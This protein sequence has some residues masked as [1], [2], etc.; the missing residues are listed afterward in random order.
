MSNLK[1]F[2]SL[3]LCIIL[4]ISAF[5]IPSSALSTQDGFVYERSED[6]TACITG[7][8]A[9]NTEIAIPSSIEGLSVKIIKKDAFEND[10]KSLKVSVPDSVTAIASDA[11]RGTKSLNV[12][13]SEN[14]FAKYYAYTQKLTANNWTDDTQRNPD[15]VTVT[16]NGKN[17]AY[18]PCKDVRSGDWYYKAAEFAGQHGFIKGYNNGSFGANDKMQRQDF[19]VILSRLVCYIEDGETEFT[20]VF[21][22]VSDREQ[23]FFSPVTYLTAKGLVSGY[24]DG[25]FGV[26]DSITREQVCTLLWR[27]AKYLGADTDIK[28]ADPLSAFSDKNKVSAFS[29]DAVKWCVEN[30]IINGSKGKLEPVKTASRAEV[31]ALIVNFVSYCIYGNKYVPAP[32]PE[33]EVVINNNGIVSNAPYYLKVNRVQNIVI[34][35]KKD[36]NGHY[37]IPVKAM[38]CSVGLNGKTP[39]GT[40]KTTD[41]YTWRL[42]S[43][44]VWGQYATRITGHYLFHSV[45]YFTQSK[46]NLEYEE[47]NKLGQAASLGCVRLSVADA[48]W[49]Y[50]NCPK[51]TVVTIYDSTAKEP[52]AKPVPIKINVNDSRRGW[53]P[54]DPDPRNPW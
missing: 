54:T 1:R 2:L 15:S 32:E 52:M 25:R 43:G 12:I 21:S 44:N 23:Y 6:G 20:P 9:G 49:I 37:N 26:G 29:Q 31:T 11:F 39:T 41:K 4:L 33:P 24:Q 22:D 50:D 27:T 10:G 46:S 18:L 5:L 42:L 47:Y 51:S 36:A 3:F 48:K 53:D 19:A 38:A 7:Y 17:A 28:S 13:C 8:T 30:H 45:P 16:L 35:Y 40:Y 34:A 14:S